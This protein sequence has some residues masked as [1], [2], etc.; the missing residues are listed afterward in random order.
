[1]KRG[2]SKVTKSSE[3]SLL[4]GIKFSLYGTALSGATV[5]EYATTDKHGVSVG[6]INAALISPRE[7]FKS[8]ILSNAASIIAVHN[9]PSGNVHPLREDKLTTQ[10]LREAGEL[11]VYFYS[12][13]IFN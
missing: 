10:R 6:T 9:H 4:E 13:K 12:L 3:D 2:D 8:G 11:L 5:N 7:V 1:M